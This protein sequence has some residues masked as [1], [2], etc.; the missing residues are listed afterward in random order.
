MMRLMVVFLMGV[1]TVGCNGFVK[2]DPFGSIN[3]SYFIVR[4]GFPAPLVYS[5]SA[6]Q[7]NEDY[8]VSVR[9][10]PHIAN[11]AYSC[12]TDCDL[13]FIKH[14][15]KDNYP[16]WRPP[17]LGE[18]ITA[19]GLSPFQ[20]T[21][22]GK[23]KIYQTP[24]VNTA[25]HSGDLYGIHDAPLVRGMSGGPV[26]GSDGKALGI[27]TGF[28]SV[29]LHDTIVQSHLRGAERVSV[30]IPYS[31]IAREWLLFQAQLNKEKTPAV[32]TQISLLKIQVPK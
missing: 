30:F 28:Y 24:F 9:H 4:S 5:A 3:D 7:W 2:P 8:A 23:G 14:K 27:N 16:L 13:V 18:S 21:T 32:I 25:E 12:S 29:T 6:V 17:V 22:T 26:I 19:V 10:T 20:M 11:I 1:F 31:I 15:A